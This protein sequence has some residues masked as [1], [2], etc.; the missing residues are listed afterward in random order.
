MFRPNET[1]SFIHC[2]IELEY[3]FRF[4]KKFI[5]YELNLVGKPEPM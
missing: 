3:V 4:Y 2:E 1:S 5:R